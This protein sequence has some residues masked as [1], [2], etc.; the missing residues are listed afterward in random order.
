MN[1]RFLLIHC[2]SPRNAVS[3]RQTITWVACILYTSTLA[4]KSRIFKI[5]HLRD[6]IIDYL[7]WWWSLSDL[8]LWRDRSTHCQYMK[9]EESAS[10]VHMCGVSCVFYTEWRSC[11][12]IRLI[13]APLDELLR[14]CNSI[15]G[16]QIALLYGLDRDVDIAGMWI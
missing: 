2:S 12:Q 4:L 16:L 13:V 11:L 6:I 10:I 3:H 9:S 1:I 7:I 8:T 15:K 5:I 14:V